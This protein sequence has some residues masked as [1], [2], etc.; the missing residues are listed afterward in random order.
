MSQ[1]V[2]QSSGR[3]LFDSK[4]LETTDLRLGFAISAG[5][6]PESQR[7]IDQF[8]LNAEIDFRSSVLT[9]VLITSFGNIEHSMRT[10]TEFAMYD[11][12]LDTLV[13][14]DSIG[15]KPFTILR[16]GFFDNSKDTIAEQP[17]TISDNLSL[18]HL[19]MHSDTFML[20]SLALSLS[21]MELEAL[22]PSVQD[23]EHQQSIG[24][25]LVDNLSKNISVNLPCNARLDIKLSTEPIAHENCWYIKGQ[26][27]YSRYDPHKS[28]VMA[29]Q[30]ALS[31][32]SM[33]L[34][35]RIQSFVMVLNERSISTDY[36]VSSF[37][38]TDISL[39]YI[40]IS[41]S[42]VD[43]IIAVP[44]GSILPVK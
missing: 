37:I 15:I 28:Y 24:K 12:P 19:I 25:F 43:V 41:E 44:I 4:N 18:N 27:V 35:N 2:A 39:A 11:G 34:G 23:I 8:W 32:L 17:I 20:D 13:V 10:L 30:D 26:A 33:F 6:N 1:I 7:S 5:L 16:V 22:L 42:L 14:I 21:Q 9:S 29:R 3:I 31:R 40:Q 36:Q 38:F